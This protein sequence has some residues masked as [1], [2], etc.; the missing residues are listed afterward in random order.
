[1]DSYQDVTTEIIPNL[2]R[3]LCDGNPEVVKAACEAAIELTPIVNKDERGSMILTHVLRLTHDEDEE[4]KLK[5]LA[6]LKEI[7]PHLNAEVSEHFVVPDIMALS[8]DSIVK[9]RKLVAFCIPKLARQVQEPAYLER[10]LKVYLS[11]SNDPIWGV[12][13]CCV[14]GFATMIQAYNE[15]TQIQVLQP[16]FLELLKDKS[17]SVKQAALLQLGEIIAYS[18]APLPETFLDQFTAL[19]QNSNNKGEYQ[20]HCAYYLPGILQIIGPDA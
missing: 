20:H 2:D 1:M 15:Q 17:N 19:S 10:L 9:I 5:G 11:L 14:E 16:R 8:Q 18:K 7:I 4:N 6:A 12:R 3:L 13:K